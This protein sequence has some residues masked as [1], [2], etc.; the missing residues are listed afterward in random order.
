[1]TFTYTIIKQTIFGTK[2]VIY[3]K[4]ENTD[5][6][7]GGVIDL[8]DSTRLRKIE[9]VTLQEI[10]SAVVANKS[11]VVTQLPIFS[12]SFEIKTDANVSGLFI[13]TGD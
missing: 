4:F 13:V 7:T 2:R 6:S 3:G 8:F 12:A 11:V 9:N 5:E 10:G 1:M